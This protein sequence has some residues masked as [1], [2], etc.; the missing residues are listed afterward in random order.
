MDNSRIRHIAKAITWRLVASATTFLLAYLIFKDDPNAGEKATIVALIEGALKLVLYYY[1]ERF[2]FNFKAEA[3]R[4]R[5][6]L[7]SITWRGIA[8]LTTFII[9]I[10]VFGEDPNAAEKAGAVALAEIFLKMLI[11]Y[12]HEEAWYKVNFGLEERHHEEK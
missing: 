2:W 11:Y 5:H 10:L 7:K 3:T 9:T 12:L 1:H 8:S 6:I 4:K